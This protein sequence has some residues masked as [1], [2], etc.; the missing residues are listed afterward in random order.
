MIEEIRPKTSTSYEIIPKSE[1]DLYRLAADVVDMFDQANT[2]H[3]IENI[4]SRG[5]LLK[6][7]ISKLRRKL[8]LDE[9]RTVLNSNQMGEK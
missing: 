3:Q 1:S 9:Q 2:N 8:N 6:T 4:G 5:Q 7:S